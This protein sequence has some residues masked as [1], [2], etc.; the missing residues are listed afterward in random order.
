MSVP[1][2]TR[3]KPPTLKTVPESSTRPDPTVCGAP[4]GDLTVSGPTDTRC[5][6]GGTRFLKGCSSDIVLHYPRH[7][8][9]CMRRVKQRVVKFAEMFDF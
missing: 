4:A 8:Q 7:W 5:W 9:T 6:I 3:F 2:R 1:F